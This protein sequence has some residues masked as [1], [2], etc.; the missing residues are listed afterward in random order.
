MH[1]NCWA[2]VPRTCALRQETPPQWEAHAPQLEK[3]HLHQWRLSTAENKQINKKKKSVKMGSCVEG[4]VD[5]GD[6][7]GWFQTT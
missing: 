6:H 3:A 1:H 5:T 2:H 7:E 4:V